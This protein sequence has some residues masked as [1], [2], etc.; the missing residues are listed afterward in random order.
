[1]AIKRIVLDI[2]ADHVAEIQ[3]FYQYVFNLD[4]AMDLGWITTLANGAD[5]PIQISIASQG[6]S[7][8][9]VPDMSIEVDD[10]DQVYERVKG[11]DAA[12]EYDLITEPWGV[13]RFFFRDPA[14]KLINV[15][16]H[17]GSD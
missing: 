9:P 14:G 15:L 10:L 1:M 6:G 13:R 12:I 3:L 8:T 7:G 4:V 17:Q 5:G 11:R 2:A 16:E